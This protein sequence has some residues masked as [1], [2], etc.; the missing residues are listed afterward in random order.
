[1]FPSHIKNNPFTPRYIWKNKNGR[2]M[3]KVN[4]KVSM[5]IHDQKVH[6]EKDGKE[7]YMT[8]QEWIDLE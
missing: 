8:I 3:W 6:W 2:W 7:Y 1:M 5:D 4:D